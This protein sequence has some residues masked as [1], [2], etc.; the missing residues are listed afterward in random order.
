MMKNSTIDPSLKV[1]PSVHAMYHPTLGVSDLEAAREWFNR[2]FNLPDIRWEDTLDLSR[3]EPDYPVNYSFFMFIKDFHFVVLCPELHARGAMEGQSRYKGVPDG[4]IG[5]GWYTGDAV[6]MFERLAAFGFPSHDQKGHT[7]TPANRPVSSIAT[8]ILVGFTYPEH[9]GM[10]HEFEELGMSHREY[11]S[12]KADPRLRPGWVRGEVDPA[13]PLQIIQSSHHTIVTSDLARATRLYVDAAGGKIV[14]TGHNT[15]LN[16]ESTF[17]ALGDA[18]VEFAVPSQEQSILA[19][20]VAEGND[21]YL[22]I[23]LQVADL[24][25]ANAHLQKVGLNPRKIGDT[26]VTIEPEEAFGMQWRFITAL[27]Y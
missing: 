24:A 6:G 12:R 23:S 27:P 2:V 15:E 20:K 3:L 25:A 8:D 22:G 16:A 5:I 14:G 13:D 18:I 4:M 17:I 21:F 11:Y 10:R 19:K 26:V 1:L 9:A 7:I